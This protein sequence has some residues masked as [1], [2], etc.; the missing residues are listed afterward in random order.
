MQFCVHIC[1]YIKQV[2]L[3]T[4]I[5]SYICL[6]MQTYV[7]MNDVRFKL[8]SVKDATYYYA[9]DATPTNFILFITHFIQLFT[10]LH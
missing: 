7:H 10:R 8:M 1:T 6:H 9:F 3:Q 4:Y 5:H 2:S